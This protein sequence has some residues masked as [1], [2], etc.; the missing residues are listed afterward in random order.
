MLKKHSTPII[1]LL[2]VALAVAV[3]LALWQFREAK[4]AEI[5]V[6]AGR[7]RAYYSALDSLTNLEADLSKALVASGPGQH[8][9]LLGR[10][11]SLAGAASENLS[12]LPAA[13]GADES[14]LKFLGQTADYAQ[15]LAAAAAEGRTLS[16]TDVRQ[17]SQLMQ[18]SGELRRHL[19]NGEGFAYD[20]PS[21]EQKLSGIEY[22]SLLYDGPFS[23]GVRQGAPRGLSGEEITSEQA[24]EA[25]RAFLG[26]AR[27]QRASDM[28]GP[29]P[30]WGVSAEANG[31]TITLQVT[32]QGGKILWMAPETAGFE[33][34][35]G[36]EACVARA[37][38]F[39]E[40]HGFGEMEPSFT[41]QY[42]GLAVISFAAVQDGVTLY[43]DLVK[44]QVRMDTGEVVGLEANNYWMNHTER[45]N[46]AP[47]VDEQQA[48]RAVSGRL[49]VSGSRL[50]VIPVDD[51]LD[52]GKTEKLCWEF[53][54]EWNGSRYFVYIDAETGEEEKV[55]KVVAG[56]GGTLTI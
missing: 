34:K 31:V 28:Q 51:G 25:G 29:I 26:A 42:D 18:K 19:E 32:R 40:S 11:S 27:A 48:L 13:Y 46:L 3:A 33:T 54:G 15:T 35:L 30:C 44:A 36:I 2:L 24:V 9:L 8:A 47:Q 20:A 23:D 38:E 56:N 16:E 4:A 53:A 55:L 49:T 12:A 21:E 45:E 7:E 37:R 17:L 52:S 43:P 10:V 14:G 39:L 22:P 50:C 6:R 41:Q 1:W 5:T